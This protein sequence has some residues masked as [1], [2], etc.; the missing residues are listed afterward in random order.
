MAPPIA[1]YVEIV[2]ILCT[3][4]A[5]ITTA[6]AY[7]R[8][9]QKKTQL[10][11]TI[12]LMLIFWMLAILM[13]NGK[14]LCIIFDITEGPIY[15]LF[16]T[17]PQHLLFIGLYF[18][19][20]FV[21]IVFFGE[22]TDYGRL[23]KI[24]AILIVGNITLGIIRDFFAFL[25]IPELVI[26]RDILGI[27][28][29]LIVVVPTLFG[30]LRL[31]RR[32]PKDN[33]HQSQLLHIAIMSVAYLLMVVSLIIENLIWERLGGEYP[34]EA[35]FAM[36]VFIVVQLYATYHGFFSTRPESPA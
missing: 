21:R 8:H 9:R 12:I 6:I 26:V 31:R 34:N 30:A 1:I 2:V 36:W 23:T 25:F 5:I 29:S 28:V 18:M 32:L 13:F 7:S 3:I 11:K 19:F 17:T 27:A 16:Y 14:M 33:P 24:V 15:L 20:G 22:G 10:T 35:S 4:Y